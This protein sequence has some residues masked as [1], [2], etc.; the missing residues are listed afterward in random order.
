MK[1]NLIV[2]LLILVAVASAQAEIRHAK[3]KV[4][5]MD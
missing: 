3:I 4:L 1:R 5:G 2:T